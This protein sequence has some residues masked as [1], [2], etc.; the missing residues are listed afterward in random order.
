[1]I[2]K[3][4]SLFAVMDALNQVR[5]RCK[6]E[7]L[8]S[9]SH[10]VTGRVAASF[11]NTERCKYRSLLHFFNDDAIVFGRNSSLYSSHSRFHVNPI[12]VRQILPIHFN[13]LLVCIFVQWYFG[14]SLW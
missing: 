3:E 13:D 2:T 4:E 14:N 9:H 5:R 7:K 11:S 1:M 12:L 8:L 10:E 6:A